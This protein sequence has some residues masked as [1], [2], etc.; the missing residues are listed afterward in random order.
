M[1]QPQFRHE[2]LDNGPDALY[3][4]AKGNTICSWRTKATLEEGAYRFEGKIRTKEIRASGGE[5]QSGA[6]LRISGGGVTAELNGTQD[7]QKFAYPFRVPEGG[8]DVEV[9]CELRASR[10]EA[11]F[12]TASL[13]LV[14]LR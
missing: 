11:W 3:L 1:G 7:W 10:G 14:R 4:A 12:D 2:K 6:G 13:R 5:P 8:G 9:V